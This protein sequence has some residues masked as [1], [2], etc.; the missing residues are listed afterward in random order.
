MS[1][2]ERNS[3]KSTCCY[4]GVGCGIVVTTD[5]RGNISIEGDKNNPVNEGKLCSKGMNLH[6]TVADKTDRLLYPQM[7]SGRDQP[8]SRVSWDAALDRA[9]AVFKTIIE[10][11]GPDA[12]GFYGAGQILTEEYYIINKLVKGFLKTNNL[13]TSSRLCMRDLS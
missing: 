3:V 2:P 6:Y 10:K 1:L 12:V 11:F 5:R 9:A 13:D 8:L 4:C 7:R